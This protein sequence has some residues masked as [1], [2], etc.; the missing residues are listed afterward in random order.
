MSTSIQPSP[1]A[2]KPKKLAILSSRFWP[3]SGSDELALSDL[4]Q[5]LAEQGHEVE[6]IT[7]GW[8]TASPSAFR[9]RNFNVLRTYRSTSTPWAGFQYQKNL[10]RHL[11]QNP[12]D[13]L[14]FF[15]AFS[16]FTYL[17]KMF[18][19]KTTLTVRL[20]DHV[21]LS[22]TGQKSTKNCRV[23]TLKLADRVFV[24]SE[25]SFQLL[26][27]A[28]LPV[29]KLEVVPEGILPYEPPPREFANQAVA[30]QAIGQAHG[31]LT[32]HPAQPLLVCGAPMNGD[33]GVLDLVDA[34]RI[35]LSEIPAAKLWIISQ[36]AGSRSVWDAITSKQMIDSVIMPGQFDSFE[37]VF[38]AADGYLHPLRGSVPCSMLTRAMMAGL[39]P[40]VT[41]PIAESLDLTDG[42]NV[43]I[44]APNNH[45]SLANAIVK[46][47]QDPD[48]RIRTGL[49]AADW[50][51]NR[52]HISQTVNHYLNEV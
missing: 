20:H 27:T 39:C 3:C 35:V 50:A 14:I 5:A 37:D 51:F 11:G 42:L 29:Q 1:D 34:W 41:E 46:T 26:Q 52:F 15:N 48:Q 16:E 30:R 38:R 28:G 31:M 2:S 6:V 4:A 22:P 17:A 25:S 18:V 44:A 8:S 49:A 33:Q 47:I 10:S 19:G 7:P 24:E 23:G 36:G 32:V 40:I 43:N 13:G 9:Y 21:L 45:R 12:A